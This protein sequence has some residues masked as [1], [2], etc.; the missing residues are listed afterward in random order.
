MGRRAVIGWDIPG[1][2]GVAVTELGAGAAWL[3]DGHADTEGSYLPGHGLAEALDAEL[4]GMVDGTAGI[5]HDTAIRRN[6][7]D[8]AGVL[9]AHVGDGGSDELH[10]S[11][12]VGS[13]D[14]IDFG[15]R[16]LFSRAEETVARVADN[17]VH[18]PLKKGM[19]DKRVDVLHLGQIQAFCLERPG[20]LLKKI[21]D[22]ATVTHGSDDPV[23]PCEKLSGHSFAEA[24]AHPGNKPRSLFHDFFPLHVSAQRSKSS[25]LFG[26][27]KGIQ[28]KPSY[29]LYNK[30]KKNSSVFPILPDSKKDT[31]P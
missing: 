27:S 7:N 31:E 11:H 6:L 26:L 24:A 30:T 15:V 22:L 28:K 13:N 10:G 16:H 5:C 25:A 2:L 8:T 18:L 14:M 12:K 20:I 29:Q 1:H 23:A 9:A 19:I 17:D 21:C 4:G 3:H